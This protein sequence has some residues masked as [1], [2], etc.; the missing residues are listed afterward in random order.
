MKRAMQKQDFEKTLNWILEEIFGFPLNMTLDEA[1]EKLAFDIDLPKRA[2]DAGTGKPLWVIDHGKQFISEE[3]VMERIK[4]DDYMFKRR[5]IPDIHD[6][7]K[8]WKTINAML[9]EKIIDSDNVLESD[10]I[11][12]SSAVFRSGYIFESKHIL[13]SYA[14]EKS[15]YVAA[16]KQNSAIQFSARIFSSET[17]VN[18]F[19]VFYS[20]Q[21]RN[22]LFI[23]NSADLSD[24]LFCSNLRSKRF[25]IANTQYEESEY[26]KMKPAILKEIVKA[27]TEKQL[28]TLLIGH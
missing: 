6:I 17:C 5:G 26:K 18:S 10:N 11:F 15:E 4:E 3:S 22:S 13:F 7:I 25:C 16:S 1:R 14:L 27:I 21:V 2:T 28:D 8:R 23:H 19:E 12:Q 24:C 20:S 9:G